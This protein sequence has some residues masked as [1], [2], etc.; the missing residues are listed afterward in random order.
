[1]Q[2]GRESQAIQLHTE[3]CTSKSSWTFTYPFKTLCLEPN[4]FTPD[5]WSQLAIARACCYRFGYC[6]SLWFCTSCNRASNNAKGYRIQ[7]DHKTRVYSAYCSHR[8]PFKRN[9]DFNCISMLLIMQPT[10]ARAL[11]GIDEEERKR[12]TATWSLGPGQVCWLSKKK[13]RKE[14]KACLVIASLCVSLDKLISRS[15]VHYSWTLWL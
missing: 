15:L 9:G 1:M 2:V 11:S 3:W 5:D 10:G 14:R 13:N 6:R 8:W 7:S 12:E 4:A